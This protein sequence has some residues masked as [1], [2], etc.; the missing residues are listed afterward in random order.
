MLYSRIITNLSLVCH[1]STRSKLI[2][3]SCILH[4]DIIHRHFILLSSEP[5]SRPQVLSV[6]VKHKDAHYTNRR[7]SSE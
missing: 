7:Q 4:T 1:K 2:V 5:T 3:K 6:K